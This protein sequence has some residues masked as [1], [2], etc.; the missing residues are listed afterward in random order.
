MKFALFFLSIPLFLQGLIPEGINNILPDSYPQVYELK[1]VL[2]FNPQGWYIH[3]NAFESLL[4]NNKV[5]VAIEVGSW[6]GASARDIATILPADGVLFA[7]DTWL[8]SEEHQPGQSGYVIPIDLLFQQFLSNVIHAGLKD[9]IVPVRLPS[10]VAAKKL[11][12]LGV[13]A[14]FI[15]IDAAHD[16]ESVKQDLHA[17]YPLLREGGVFCGDDFHHGPV[18]QAVN[19]FAAEKNL[20]IVPETCWLLAK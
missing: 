1:E 6:L 18:I 19:E 5:K 16:Y 12:A 17:W 14:D 3:H 2:P 9:K 8:G 10:V 11:A 7:V 20:K 4:R 15:Y 13:M